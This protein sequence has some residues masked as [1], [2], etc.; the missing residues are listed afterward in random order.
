MSVLLFVLGFLAL[1]VGGLGL[2]GAPL[3][4]QAYVAPILLIGA[5]WV[6]FGAVVE[7]LDMVRR[8]IKEAAPPPPAA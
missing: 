6:G 5:L 3:I 2:L 1:A 7:R 8:A 4:Y